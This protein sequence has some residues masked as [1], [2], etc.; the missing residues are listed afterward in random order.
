LETKHLN[1]KNDNDCCCAW[2]AKQAE[3][4]GFASVFGSA[5]YI[6]AKGGITYI[7]EVIEK[8]NNSC[9]NASPGSA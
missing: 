2:A 6:K 4:F 5:L 7:K 1:D 3:P 9:S 8:E